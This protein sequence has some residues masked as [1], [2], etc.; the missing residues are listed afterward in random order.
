M[1]KRVQLSARNRKS[2]KYGHMFEF[3][4]SRRG[5]K[6]EEREA[7]RNAETQTG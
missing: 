5:G 2:A 3:S 7:N 6:S 1:D 4:V